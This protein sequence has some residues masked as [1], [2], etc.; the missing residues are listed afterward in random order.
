MVCGMYFHISDDGTLPAV[1]RAMGI[2]MT[3]ACMTHTPIPE[4]VTPQGSQINMTSA[5]SFSCDFPLEALAGFYLPPLS[6]Q[7]SSFQATT[8]PLKELDVP[9]V[10]MS[11]R[12]KVLAA[13]HDLVSSHV[14]RLYEIVESIVTQQNHGLAGDELAEEVERNFC[15][16]L[17]AQRRR[18]VHTKEV[19]S[20]V[21]LLEHKRTQL[22]DPNTIFRLDSVIFINAARKA[23]AAGRR[24]AF[25]YYQTEGVL[26]AGFY[27]H[28]LCAH[29]FLVH[30]W[31]IMYALNY[32]RPV[33][34]SMAT[35]EPS[36]SFA[37]DVSLNLYETV[38]LC[39]ALFGQSGRAEEHFAH[40]VA[41]SM[42]AAADYIGSRE[43]PGAQ[44]LTLV[45]PAENAPA[46]E[47]EQ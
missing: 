31:L 41:L 33:F 42:Q 39:A 4:D 21:S 5:A 45:L 43:T 27:T 17:K 6:E 10:A 29:P 3:T 46:P 30:S 28:C 25:L 9:G 13:A 14:H 8:R 2:G 12:G 40:A 32:T 36:P 15:I 20:A 16:A 11:T 37:E 38:E 44:R 23:H 24:E 18:I 26:R 34:F 1:L 19:A 47:S 7:F 35:T 22:I